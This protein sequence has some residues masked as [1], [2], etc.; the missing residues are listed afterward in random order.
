MPDD[1]DGLRPFAKDNLN[2]PLKHINEVFYRDYD[3]EFFTNK[4]AFLGSIIANPKPIKEHLNKGYKV[5]KIAVGSG[6]NITQKWLIGYSKRE[7]VINSYHAIESFFRLFFA[8]IENPECPWVG[9]EQMQSF[10]KFK[11]RIEKLLHRKYFATDHDEVIASVLLGNRTMYS[12]LTDD[13]W[14]ESVKNAVHLVDRLGRDILSNQDYNVYKHGAALLDTKFGFKIDDGK[15]LGADNQDSFMYLS[16][17]TELMLDKK[18]VRFQK[19][20]KF[21]RWQQRVSSTFLAGQLMHNMLAIQKLRLK[22]EQPKGTKVYSF[23]KH[24]IVKLLEPDNRGRIA[25]PSTISESLFERHFE[26][27]PEPGKNTNK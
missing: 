2:N 26:I 8:H 23:H 13:E 9:V 7:L 24:D 19:T 25:M 21:M 3:E 11:K 27:T 18:V 12:Q 6:N 5:G 22:L 4:A 15:I 1:R 10:K 16:S 14:Q 20:F 17:E